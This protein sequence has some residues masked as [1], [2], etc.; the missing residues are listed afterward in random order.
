MNN[1]P[2][3]NNQPVPFKNAFG[4][5]VIEKSKVIE[6]PAIFKYY[7]EARYESPRLID[8]KPNAARNKITEII[9]KLY[10]L[11]GYKIPEDDKSIGFM[12]DEL[13]VQLKR[14][15]V[16]ITISEIKQALESGVNGEF[17][18]ITGNL[19]GINVANCMAWIFEYMR[20]QQRK[21]ALSDAYDMF[22]QT[23]NPK[24]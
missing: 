20:S 13:Y 9:L 19:L 24:S 22:E 15:Y 23:L 3:E 12:R 7:L 4:L 21:D 1:L 10:T 5:S 14:K 8:L 17:K 16:D 11:T 6:A 18:E 2:A